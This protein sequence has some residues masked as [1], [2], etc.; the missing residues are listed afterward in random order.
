LLGQ[1]EALHAYEAGATAT[2]PPQLDDI[3]EA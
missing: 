2:E 1:T 3:E